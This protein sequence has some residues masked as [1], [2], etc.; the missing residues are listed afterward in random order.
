MKRNDDPED[1]SFYFSLG[2]SKV[3]SH[4]KTNIRRICDLSIHND[5][6]APLNAM[7]GGMR[8]GWAASQKPKPPS[9]AEPNGHR[10]FA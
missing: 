1:A 2:H 4:N 6:N 9:L 5:S 7:R 10:N 3:G 8:S